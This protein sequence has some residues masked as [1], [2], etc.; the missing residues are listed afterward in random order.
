M[1]QVCKKCW[2][3][4]ILRNLFTVVLERSLWSFILL[5][6]K[7]QSELIKKEIA[8]VAK[9]RY[10]GSG[11]LTSIENKNLKKCFFNF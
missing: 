4:Y 7:G 1:Y 6:N 3:V 8:M 11:R 9:K 2:F 5:R 10:M